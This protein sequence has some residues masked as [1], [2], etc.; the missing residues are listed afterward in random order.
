MNTNG[1]NTLALSLWGMGDDHDNL[2]V[3]SVYL[4]HDEITAGGVGCVCF[5]PPLFTMCLPS[6]SRADS[7]LLPLC[8]LQLHRDVQPWLGRVRTTWPLSHSPDLNPPPS[9]SAPSFLSTFFCSILSRLDFLY[10]SLPLRSLL[11]SVFLTRSCLLE[12]SRLALSH[13]PFCPDPCITMIAKFTRVHLIE[14][15]DAND[16]RRWNLR[17]CSA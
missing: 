4:T 8:S 7:T 2:S 17:S 15:R 14:A 10:I 5:P 6:Q 16:E 1:T 12:G 13:L 9:L 3:E 11:Y